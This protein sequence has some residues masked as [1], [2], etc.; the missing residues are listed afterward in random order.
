[1]NVYEK[2]QKC[3]VELQNKSLKKSGN[4][5][6]AGYKYFELQ[7]FLPEVNKLCLENK[8]FTQTSFTHDLATL[9]IINSEDPS[10]VIIF[11]SPQAEANLKGCHAIQNI[12]AVE[13]YQRRYLLMLA[14]EI[15]EA[16][17]LD[18]TTGADTQ[19]DNMQKQVLSDAQLNKLYI[20][21]EKAGFDKATVDDQIK[22]KFKVDTKH[23]TKSVYD[24]AIEGYEKFIKNKGEKAN[25]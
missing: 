2:L 10:E 5:K 23:M 8:L 7:D 14:F 24:T 25:E 1:M 17:N 3:R 9:S 21:A 22:K 15:V 20:I 4:N 6:F 12:G 16:D 18:A 13:T 19:K 11:T